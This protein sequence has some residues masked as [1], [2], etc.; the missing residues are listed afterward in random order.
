[1]VLDPAT[2]SGGTFA[3]GQTAAPV[4]WRRV[5]SKAGS[6]DSYGS[7]LVVLAITYVTSVSL[8]ADWGAS[9]VLALQ[10]GTT[11]VLVTPDVAPLS[12]AGGFTP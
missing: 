4:G 10:I 7:V 2:G 12:A 5:L 11:S 3:P 1:M 8:H 6:P 9:V